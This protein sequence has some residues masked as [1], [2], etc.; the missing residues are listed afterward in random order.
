MAGGI[1][2]AVGDIFAG[3]G[4]LE[5]ADAYGTAAEL[6]DK[7]ADITKRSTAIQE[8]QAQ[9]AIFKTIGAEDAA[10]SGAGFVAGSGS[11][12]DLLR[13]STAQAGLTRQLVESQGEITEQGYRQQAAAYRGQEAAANMQAGGDFAGGILG[14]FGF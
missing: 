5:S 4:A 1:G 10:T 2:G 7:N 11:G 8:Q 14:I 9:Q 6:S 3:F 12:G 13:A